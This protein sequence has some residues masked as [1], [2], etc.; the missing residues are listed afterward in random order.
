VIEAI[1]KRI[2]EAT[3]NVTVNGE[4]IR[5]RHPREDVV[6]GTFTVEEN[7]VPDTEGKTPGSSG[8]TRNP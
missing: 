1:A 3:V 7:E 2:T 5:T 6:D 8:W 4:T